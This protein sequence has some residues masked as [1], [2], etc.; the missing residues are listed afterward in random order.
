MENTEADKEDGSV[1]EMIENGRK[2]SS[3]SR[4]S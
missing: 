2:Y 4:H 1:G 3:Y